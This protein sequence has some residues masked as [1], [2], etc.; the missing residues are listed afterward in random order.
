MKKKNIFIPI[1]FIAILVLVFLNAITDFLVNLQ[2][3]KEVNYLQM[4]F[5][6]L[7]A[8]AKFMIPIFL[9]TFLAIWFYY[10]S[11][12]K[13][14]PKLKVINQG[15]LKKKRIEKILLFL[16]NLF[17]SLFF[18]YKVADNYWYRI[19][20]FNNSVD[21]NVK[22]PIFNKDVS[23]YVFKL[24]LVQSIYGSILALLVFFTIITVVI[25]IINLTKDQVLKGKKP[26]KI[27]DF[28]SN[29]TK[30]FGRQMAL[31]SALIL[32]FVSFGY[33]L[34]AYYLVYSPRGVAF[35]ASY[36]DVHVT[37]LF[38]RI[39]TVTALIS[40]IVVFIS[41][42]KAKIKPIIGSILVIVVLVILEP[43]SANL[44]QQ[45]MVRP[46]EFELEKKYIEFN[47]EATR[48]AFNIDEVSE[49]SFATDKKISLND[50]T[51]N[52]DIVDNL[53]INSF[54]PVLNF[55]NQVQVIKNYYT[56]N[57]VD[58]DRY[59]INNKYNQVFISPREINSDAVDIWQ[60]KHLRYTHGYGLVMSKVNSVTPEGQPDFVMKDIPSE[61]H[62]EIKVDNPRIYFGESTNYYAVVK[63]DLMEF[64]YPKGDKSEENQY[65]GKAG[66]RMSLSNKILF[67]IYEGN[68]KI[69]LSNAINSDS[70]MLL[71]RN[72]VK[73]A[74]KIAPFLNYDKD[75]YLVINDGKL[76]W[77][78][79]AYTTTDKYPFAQP[80][81]KVN[82]IRNSIKVT[83]DA[84]D[85]DIN[86][87]IIDKND[88]I[89]ASYSK[90]FKGLFK[91]AENIPEGIKTHYRY[92]ST[93]F[94]VQCD[95]LTKYHVTNPFKFFTEEDM[96]QIST[97]QKKTEAE[98][99]VNESSYIMTRLPGEEKTEMM[100]FEYFNIKNKQNMVSI[101]GARMDG[102]DYGKLILYKFPPQKTVYSPTLFMNKINQDTTISKEM[103]LWNSK[104]SSVD[105]GDT[106]II[107]INESL[108]YVQTLYLRSGGTNSIPEMKRVI[109]FDGE[110][111]VI[112]ENIE[113]ALA[114][115]FNYS[116][117]KPGEVNPAPKP[118][119]PEAN[120]EMK[121][122]KEIYDKAI[123]A[124]KN[125][126]WSKYG[127]YI[128]ELGDIIN[129]LNK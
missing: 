50:I 46:N 94:D 99:R 45:F 54:E 66:I 27:I 121:K 78:L 69:L 120:A 59:V 105:Y 128:K 11:I 87:Y 74:E 73:R 36:T 30:F 97:T 76:V 72:I 126:D 14:I 118:E 38:Y 8:V 106:L 16:G 2:W 110:R 119:T 84:Y 17:V 91:D 5:I 43:I 77:V 75:P 124:Q 4:Y 129:N 103:S 82:Y 92:P 98:N 93:L 7:T 1:I 33:I 10:R 89:A 34:K 44:V 65:D 37:L 114:S 51:K 96:W 18:S 86:F 122:A 81:K 115:L 112:E 21:F 47:I 123:E 35:G 23:F 41:L 104:G 125:G 108:L 9:I 58:T 49:I 117:E 102:D 48:K 57:D 39:I 109:L 20:Q 68:A 53:K 6:K 22:D 19:L 29:L 40:A 12:V 61:N 15:N 63:T 88:P 13:S 79:D 107:P 85:G 3:F 42:M 70:K 116:I 113:K 60:N 101:F 80:Y 31:L 90:I 62:T 111:L 127:E 95:V 100:L 64:D 71:N 26:G 55:Y 25:Y 28:S 83:V 52:K 24:P 56:F 32:L 67:S